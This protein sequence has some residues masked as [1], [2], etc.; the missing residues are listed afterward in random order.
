MVSHIHHQHDIAT[1]RKLRQEII[2]L[3][4]EVGEYC[5]T[6]MSLEA[7]L[8]PLREDKPCLPPR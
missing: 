4:R 7:E 2:A 1:I 3:E 5:K 6:I 8:K